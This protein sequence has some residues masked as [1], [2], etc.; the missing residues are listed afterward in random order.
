[1]KTYS[2]VAAALCAA[3]AMPAQAGEAGQWIWRAGVHAVQP[4]SDNHAVVNV[5]EAAMLTFGGTYLITPHW[6]VEV[7]AALPFSHDIKLNG[8]DKVAETEHLPPTVSLQY[9][10]NPA[11]AVR[12]Y[13]GVGLN[14]TV[15]FSEKTSGALEGSKLGLD[16]SFDYAA[17]H[18]AEAFTEL[19]DQAR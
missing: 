11:G 14:Y 8:G 5:D 2:I 19:G 1:M 6:G 17:S 18:L 10:L 16:P 13:F 9:H 4:K 15:F 3:A 7:L 12:P